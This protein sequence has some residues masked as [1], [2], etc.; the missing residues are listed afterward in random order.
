MQLT[1]RHIIIQSE[2]LEQLC[3]KAARLYNFINYHKRQAFFGKQEDFSEYEISG[4]CAE[5]KQDDYKNLPAQTSQQIIKQV[6]KAWKSYFKALKEFRKYPAKFLGRPKPPHYKKK[7]GLGTVFFTAQQIKLKDGIVKF[8]KAS[9]IPD[10]QTKVDNLCQVRIIPQAT[11][12]VIEIIY[13]KKEETHENIKKENV[14]MIDLGLNNIVT[15]IDNVGNRPFIINGRILKSVNQYFNRRRA[16][17]MSYVGNKGTSKRI[18]KLT[19]KRNNKVSDSLHKI[20]NFI[21]KYCLQHGI[22]T[23]VIGKNDHWKQGGFSTPMKADTKRQNNQN[24]ISVPHA[25][26]IDQITYKL[27]LHGIILIVHEESHTSKCDHFALETIEHHDKYL[28]RRVG[29]GRFKSSTGKLLNAD[30]N[31]AIG[32]GRKSKVVQD[33]FILNLL[34]TGI[35]QMPYRVEYPVKSFN[36][37]CHV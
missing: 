12:F 36:T 20:S 4:L 28:G 24:F 25:K 30:V 8:P 26:L 1:E 6:F 14:L 16:K 15:A 35:A 5:F 23:V 33:D 11:C 31:G 2:P 29:R 19:H 17:L 32:I 13:E 34:N 9:N 10:L 37:K 22:G 18:E 21:L 7:D 3:F 27:A